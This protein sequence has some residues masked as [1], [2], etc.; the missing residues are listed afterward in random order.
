M[1]TENPEINRREQEQQGQNP[2]KQNP[3]QQN[4]QGG[5]GSD[6]LGD[7]RRKDENSAPKGGAT[8]TGGPGGTGG[9]VL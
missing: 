7:T 9:S 8:G 1:G 2:Q 3:G 5:F 4:Q 6:E